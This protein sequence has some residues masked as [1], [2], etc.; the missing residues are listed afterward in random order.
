ME[1][2]VQYMPYMYCKSP[3]KYSHIMQINNLVDLVNKDHNTL[4]G[5]GLVIHVHNNGVSNDVTVFDDDT[6]F[7]V[8]QLSVTDE[9]VNAVKAALP[10]AAYM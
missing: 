3:L 1:L 7:I 5:A 6:S 10:L 9:Q 8:Q 4:K 2:V